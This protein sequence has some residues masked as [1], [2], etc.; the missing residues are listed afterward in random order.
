VLGTGSNF[1][2][3]L[4][5]SMEGEECSDCYLCSGVQQS[6]PVAGILS[7]ILGHRLSDNTPS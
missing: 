6:A 1:I 4:S 5:Q 3:M 7:E 2:V